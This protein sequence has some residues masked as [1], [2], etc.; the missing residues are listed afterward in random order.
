MSLSGVVRHRLAACQVRLVQ[1]S[2]TI[3]YQEPDLNRVEHTGYKDSQHF[4]DVFNTIRSITYG[5]KEE[6]N[7]R[8]L[9]AL[10]TLATASI[11]AEE[12]PA[13]LSGK[14]G[15]ALAE[16]RA[17]K[18]QNDR[19]AAGEEL[20]ALVTELDQH[21]NVVR[22]RIKNLNEQISNM[23]D[24]LNQIDR[25]VAYGE[26]TENFIPLMVLLGHAPR[27]D[28]KVPTTVPGTWAP[29]AVRA[30]AAKKTPKSK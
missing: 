25:A 21:K 19:L 6:T 1:S 24:T 13:V 10:A 11:K 8:H 12:E 20:V 9:V 27:V 16:A 3:P 22:H 2:S 28:S 15:Q 29:A 30:E 17:K 23:K 14:L 18:E 5:K 4:A 26:E 7:M